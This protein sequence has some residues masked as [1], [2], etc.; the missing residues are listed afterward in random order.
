[1]QFDEA[2]NVQISLWS[3]KKCFGNCRSLSVLFTL[4]LSFVFRQSCK[5]FPL[6]MGLSISVFI[7]MS[8]CL[9][10]TFVSSGRSFA[11]AKMKNVKNAFLNFGICHRVTSFIKLY[12]VIVTYF[13]KVNFF[14]WRLWNCKSFRKTC[15]S[16]ICRPTFAVE[17]RHC[18]NCTLWRRPTF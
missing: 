10:A 1:M 3:W 15:V 12:S 7:C 9:Y 8:V 6:A 18:E 17:C 11:K 13:L 14:L 5:T 2:W 4:K 16:D